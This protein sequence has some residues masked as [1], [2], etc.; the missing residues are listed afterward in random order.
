M[1]IAPSSQQPGAGAAATV[2]CICLC[3]LL[4]RRMKHGLALGKHPGTT[5]TKGGGHPTIKPNRLDPV[6]GGDVS[7]GTVPFYINSCRPYHNNIILSS[8][9]N[10]HQLRASHLPSCSRL[11]GGGSVKLFS[12]GSKEPSPVVSGRLVGRSV[13]REQARWT[14]YVEIRFVLVVLQ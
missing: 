5:T 9:S 8:R 12:K 10:R 11:G 2:L 1:A 4:S 6:E 7:R 3:F 14:C 13:G